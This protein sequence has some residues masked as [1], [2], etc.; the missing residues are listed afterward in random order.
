MIGDVCAATLQA[1]YISVLKHA[2]FH[3]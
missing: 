1:A 2:I 3:S